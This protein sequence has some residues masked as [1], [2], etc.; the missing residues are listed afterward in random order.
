MALGAECT[1]SPAQTLTNPDYHHPTHL[2]NTSKKGRDSLEVYFCPIHYCLT[3]KVLTIIII[4]MLP[5]NLP[6]LKC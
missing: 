3:V 6:I 5:N 2:P 1:A 4:L